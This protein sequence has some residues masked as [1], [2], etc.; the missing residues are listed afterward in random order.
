MYLLL[1]KICQYAC[2]FFFFLDEIKEAVA[3]NRALCD[4]N[5]K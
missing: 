1:L 2:I 5:I 3:A 4:M